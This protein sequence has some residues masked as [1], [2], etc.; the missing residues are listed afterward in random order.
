[1]RGVKVAVTIQSMGGFSRVA[2]MI[3]LGLSGRGVEFRYASFSLAAFG[4][5]GRIPVFFFL[6]AALRTV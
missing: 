2:F 1:M 6:L 3:I 4:Y 5:T